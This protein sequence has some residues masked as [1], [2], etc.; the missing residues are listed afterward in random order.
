MPWRNSC[1]ATTDT[2]GKKKYTIGDSNEAVCGDDQIYN[3]LTAGCCKNAIVA[4]PEIN[5]WQ[6]NPNFGCCDHLLM[7]PLKEKCCRKHHYFYFDSHLIP[8]KTEL[9]CCGTGYYN[10]SAEICNNGTVV[11]KQ[12][13][14]KLCGYT[15]YDPKVEG[16]CDFVIYEKRNSKCCKGSTRSVARLEDKCC[17]GVG[18]DKNHICCEGLLAKKNRQDDVDCCFSNDFTKAKA[19]SRALGERCYQGNIISGYREGT[20]PC[21]AHGYYDPRMEICCNNN[22]FN[23]SYD[24][25]DGEAYKKENQMCCFDKVQNLPTAL[26]N[27]CDIDEKAYRFNDQSNPCK[28]LCG[29]TLYDNAKEVCCENEIYREKR[30]FECCGNAYIN[31]YRKE[32]CADRHPYKIRGHLKCCANR[33]LYN[34]KA[35][36]CNTQGLVVPKYTNQ[37]CLPRFL[38]SFHKTKLLSCNSTYGVRGIIEK[39][40]ITIQNSS[41]TDTLNIYFTAD[42]GISKNIGGSADKFTSYASLT[43]HV[44]VYK[45]VSAKCTQHLQAKTRVM[46]FFDSEPAANIVNI[47]PDSRVFLFKHTPKREQE[48]ASCTVKVW[49]PRQK[50]D[51]VA[52]ME[53]GEGETRRDC[54]T[55]A[56]GDSY[57]GQERCVAAG[58]D[59]GDIKLFDLRNM[60]L[61]WET[62]VKNGVCCL[63]FDR[64]DIPMNK[65]VATTLESKFHVFDMRTQHPSKGFASLTERAHKSTVW[66]ARHLPQNR[67]VFMTLGGNGSLNLW[68]YSYPS[69]RSRKDTDGLDVGIAE[70]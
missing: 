51:P 40:S 17:N 34:A 43:F 69:S 30:D 47:G 58:Y 16:C 45:T 53:P 19:Y 15:Y 10:R 20:E 49:D 36:S 62:N 61:K 55:V 64:K 12:L 33:K 29:T 57:N 39:V 41:D 18:M 13:D 21:G 26:G 38:Q 65:L 50:N 24:C 42:I 25:C 68:K 37:L 3:R 32:C 60:S 31:I 27:C 56:F 2:F 8:N 4:V 9:D 6:P 14:K 54:W 1:L 46:V 67:D 23:A 35:Y 5:N 59:N 44:E 11:K 28:S 70:M 52:T 7:N 22:V 66:L 63:E 48:I